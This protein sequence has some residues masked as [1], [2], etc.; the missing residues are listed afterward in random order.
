MS[1]T[2]SKRIGFLTALLASASLLL[3]A[4][5][6]ALGAIGPKWKIESMAATTAEPGGTLRYI[7]EA[8]N[9]GDEATDGS[10]TTLEA[11]LPPGVTALSASVAHSSSFFYGCE[12]EGGGSIGG[13]SK[14]FCRVEAPL[15][16]QRTEV[17]RL[18]TAVDSG[19]SGTLTAEFKVSGGFK[20]PGGE[21]G[22]ATTVDPTRIGPPAPF[23][24]DAFDGLISA[25][26]SGAPSTQAAAHPYSTQTMLDYNT[27]DN[28]KP[29]VN[30][31]LPPE[32]PRDVFVDLPPG[33]LGNASAFPQCTVSDLSNSHGSNA[34]PLCPPESQVGTTVTRFASPSGISN[35]GPLPVFNLVPPPGVPARFGFNILS[36]VIVLDAEV[37]SDGDYGLTVASRNI[38]EGLGLAGTPV[39]FWGV[40]ADESHRLERACEGQEAPFGDGAGPTCP[41]DAPH[42]PLLRNPTACTPT[43]DT[44]LETDVHIDSWEHPGA[45]DASGAPDLSDPAW[46]SASYRSHRG[47]GYPQQ[48]SEWGEEVGIDGCAQVPFKPSFSAQPTTNT[49]DSPSGLEVDLQVPQQCWSNYE[50]ICQSDLKDAEVKL[51]VGM[52]LNPSAANGLGACSPAQIGLTTPTGVTPA[53]FSK[54]PAACPDNSKIGDVTIETPLLE[55]K[56]KGA[57]YLAKQG[58]NPFNSLLAMYLVAEA[59]ARGVVVKQAG[60]IEAG[61]GGRLTTKFTETPQTPFSD[62]H[63]SLYGGPRAALRTPPT[64]GEYTSQAKLAPWSGNPAANRA[65]VFA[66]TN[67]PKSGFDP[68]LTA[69]TQNPLAG[70]YSPFTLR[71][72]RDDG[73]E[74][75]GGLTATLPEGLIGKPAGIPY[76]SDSVLNSISGTEGTGAAQ[77]AHPSCPA[78]SQ[79]GTVTVGAGAGSNPF[80]TQSGRA[81]LAGPYKSAP[82][83]LAVVAPAVAGPFDLGSVLVRNALQV[84]PETAKITAVSDPFP[85]ALHGIGLDLRDVRVDLNRPDFTL[86]PTSCEPMSIDAQI[87]STMGASANR[88]SRFQVGGCDRLGFGPKLSLALK[89]GTKRGEDPALRATLTMPAGGAN[90]AAASVTLPHSAFLDQ[91]HIKTICTRVQYAAHQCPPGSIY[92]YARAITPLLERPLEGPVYLRSS[93]HN[94]PDLV[95]S[96]DG[97]IHIDLVGRIDSVN[98]GIRTTFE[99]VPDAPVSKFTLTMRGAKKGLIVNSRNL[100]A[101]ANRARVEFD[102]QNGKVKDFAPPLRAKCGAR[103]G[104]RRPR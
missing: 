10:Q 29:L 96:L 58:D 14:I 95:A 16:V 31:P 72:S 61:P 65:D 50:E 90:I 80:Y 70:S 27:Y 69:G 44:G 48:A 67:C 99:S 43:A 77:E 23:G 49:A 103:H 22:S 86:N 9:I 56:L 11:S 5:S 45:L 6:P 73:T 94:L 93:S 59:P 30:G 104:N 32:A 34:S 4:A 88:S 28:T 46:K 91:A 87:A 12:A 35:L 40:P 18:V 79:L 82:L 7:V 33:M 78:A 8:R 2:T 60:L 71:L 52:G 83:S 64:C 19:A 63:V 25:D 13:H 42:L 81:Y 97:Q 100:C 101:A 3:T 55:E 24:I 74:E 51:P 62:L 76:C 68:K 53:H 54:S 26:Q 38:P 17:L 85:S 98:G 102:A 41:S 20:V 1:K 92:G 21:A 57:V 84:N 47:P 66:I 15:G 89:G 75:L 36:T 37:R 39:T